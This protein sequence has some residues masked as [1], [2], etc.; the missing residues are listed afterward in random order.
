MNELHRPTYFPGSTYYFQE[1]RL[2][3]GIGRFWGDERTS[4][5]DEDGKRLKISSHDDLSATESRIGINLRAF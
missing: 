4:N 2:T 1:L 3:F 5:K